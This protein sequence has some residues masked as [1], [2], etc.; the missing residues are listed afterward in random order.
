MKISRTKI[1][2]YMECPHCFYLSE[3]RGIKRPGGFPFSINNAV[4]SL[5]KKEFDE[6][7]KNGTPHPLQ[8]KFGVNAIPANLPQIND[9][10]NAFKG[11]RYDSARHNCTFYGAID[12]MWVTPDGTY[13]VVDY[14][15]TAKMT[16]V[17]ELPEWA[18][19]YKRQA[20]IYQWLLRKNG[21]RV[22]DTAYFVYCTGNSK[23]ENFNDTLHFYSH[24]IP[25][26]GSDAWIDDA[27]E[28]M[29]ETLAQAQPPAPTPDCD[30]CNF[31]EG[32]K[33]M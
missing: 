26:N 27:I 22:S 20:E 14:K 13:H 18:D 31:I 3:S 6:H 4:D 23:H 19:A 9:W 24:V 7:R 17:I 25:Y 16:P 32:I 28:R 15:A 29:F 12:D 11:V 1:D 33:A 8:A 30:Y 5:L 2:L 21:L 10:R